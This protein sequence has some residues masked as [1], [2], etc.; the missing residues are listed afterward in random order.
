MTKKGKTVIFEEQRK[1][2]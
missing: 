2:N 1:F